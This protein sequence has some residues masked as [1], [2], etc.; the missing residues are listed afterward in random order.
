MALDVEQFSSF[1]SHQRARSEPATNSRGPKLQHTRTA[2]VEDIGQNFI[3]EKDQK[4]QAGE[5]LDT[6]TGRK[7]EEDIWADVVLQLRG[8][9][10]TRDGMA[11]CD[12]VHFNCVIGFSVLANAVCM[13][14]ET[15]SNVG[16]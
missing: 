11:L 4:K 5:E 14:L 13:G 1:S 15:D 12:T 10:M 8:G 2:H 16:S 7:V 9:P 3:L 6:Q